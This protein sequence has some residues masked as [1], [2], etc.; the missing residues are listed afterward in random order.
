MSRRALIFVLGFLRFTAPPAEERD[1]EQSDYKMMGEEA[2]GTGLPATLVQIS[3]S[4]KEAAPL[5]G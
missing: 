4:P 2:S 1:V 3:F 5:I